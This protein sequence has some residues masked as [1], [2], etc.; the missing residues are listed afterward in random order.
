MIKKLNKQEGSFILASLPKSLKEIES[1]GMPADVMG[2]ATRLLGEGY[3]ESE[4]LSQCHPSCPGKP[5][6]R[7]IPEQKI[8][9]AVGEG[10]ACR[11]L[12]STSGNI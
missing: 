9:D 12:R 1:L 3:T 2:I 6:L 11:S 7:P 10:K 4:E 8:P 5:S